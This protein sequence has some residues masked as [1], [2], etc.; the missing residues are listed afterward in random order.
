MPDT[1]TIDRLSAAARNLNDNIDEDSPD[2]YTMMRVSSELEATAQDLLAILQT[3]EDSHVGYA[4]DWSRLNDLVDAEVRVQLWESIVA[5]SSPSEELADM[6]V[7]IAVLH[8]TAAEKA[9]RL[10]NNWD[11]G[12]STDPMSNAIASITANVNSKFVRYYS[13]DDTTVKEVA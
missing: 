6:T 1:T 13:A 5:A 7:A 3:I 10:I 11:N 4:F 9:K 12:S 8:A 2:K